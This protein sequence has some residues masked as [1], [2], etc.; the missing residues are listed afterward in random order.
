[1][2]APTPAAEAR[3]SAHGSRGAPAASEAELLRRAQAA[4]AERPQEALRLTAE[5]QRRFPRAALGEE[6]EV[7]AIE[8]LRQL[9]RETAAQRREAAFERR[10]RG[11]VHREKLRDSAR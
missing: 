1:P 4:L 7:I 5:H 9:G 6:R 11:S 2:D 3:P 8:A 10:Y